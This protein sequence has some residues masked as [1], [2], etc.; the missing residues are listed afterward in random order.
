MTD[1][2]LPLPRPRRHSKKSRE[3]LALL[4]ELREVT[5][6]LLRRE[7]VARL[8][9]AR[10][11]S[12]HVHGPSRG[13]WGLPE[14][15]QPSLETAAEVESEAAVIS[16]VKRG[17]RASPLA[18]EAAGEGGNLAQSASGA[19][20]VASAGAAHPSSG[21]GEAG[22]RLWKQRFAHIRPP[23]CQHRLKPRRS[24]CTSGPTG[25]RGSGAVPGARRPH[26]GWGPRDPGRSFRSPRVTPLLPR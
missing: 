19:G 20:A 5:G 7:G 8:R 24:A 18:E 14:S 13:F 25:H 3:K 26:P 16:E 9:S 17:G 10:F 1:I 11:R 4:S 6:E 15:E 12:V 2:C 22:T 21:L 23:L